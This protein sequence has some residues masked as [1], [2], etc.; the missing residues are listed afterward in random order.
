MLRGPS[1]HRTAWTPPPR[2]PL[3]ATDRAD[4]GS[5]LV[6]ALLPAPG[7]NEL[8]RVGQAG[9]QKARGRATAPQKLLPGDALSFLALLAWKSRQ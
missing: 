1:S 8:L 5:R 2:P 4:L 9:T 6:I 3:A 7:R